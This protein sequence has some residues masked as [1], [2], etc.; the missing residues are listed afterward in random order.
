MEII[1]IENNIRAKYKSNIIS[2][3]DDNKIYT[4]SQYCYKLK[5]IIRN[6]Y[7]FLRYEINNSARH[8]DFVKLNIILLHDRINKKLL[9]KVKHTRIKKQGYS[10]ILTSENE[11]Q[12]CNR[13]DDNKINNIL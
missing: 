6:V 8:P 3:I 7:S 13:T 2:Y 4:R 9:I 11:I 12:I 5:T 10:I 1:V